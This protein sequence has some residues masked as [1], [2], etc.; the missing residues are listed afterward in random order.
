M[1]T[2]KVG[3]SKIGLSALIDT[4]SDKTISFMKPFGNW[5]GIDTDDFE[6]E[7]DELNGLFSS[8]PAW[9]KHT[10]LWIGDYRF[11]VP[12]FWLTKPFDIESDYQMVIGRKVIFD[13]FDIVF[14]QKEK[15]VYF[16]PN[17]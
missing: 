15:K 9:P 10:D 16:Y 17:R 5:L 13:N 8:G 2:V 4:G 1:I 6:G 12:I 3:K 11:N 7:P 14:R